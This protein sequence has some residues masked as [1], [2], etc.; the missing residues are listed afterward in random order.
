MKKLLL[1]HLVKKISACISAAAIA[2]TMIYIVPALADSVKIWNG[3]KD[4]AGVRYDG[5]DGTEENPFLISDGAQ[6]Y[7]MVSESN[8][9]TEKQY[10]TITRDIYLNDVSKTG[11]QNTANE[12][13]TTGEPDAYSFN[14]TVDGGGHTVFGLYIKS[15]FTPGL[16]PQLNAGAKI[17]NLTLSNA[18]VSTGWGYAGAFAGRTAVNHA[19]NNV[20]ILSCAVVNSRVS[21]NGWTLSSAAFVGLATGALSVENCL[22]RDT[23][24]LHSASSDD[25]GAFVGDCYF[26]G[27]VTVRNSY[28]LDI[29]PVSPFKNNS[30][31][32]SLYKCK[33]VYTNTDPI[34]DSHKAVA[35]VKKISADDIKGENAADTLKGFDFEYSWKTTSGF[36]EPVKKSGGL[37]SYDTLAPGQV[38]SGKPAKEYAGGSGTEDDPY[39]ISTAGQLAKL[40]KSSSE[41][42]TH[43]GEFFRL[44]H[45]IIL[46]DTSAENWQED[47]NQ[48]YTSSV[49]LNNGFGGHFDGNGKII[50]GMYIQ[51]EGGYIYAGLFPTVNV[52]SVIE[53]VGLVNSAVLL[54]TNQYE[55]VAGGIVGAVSA[56]EAL[57]DETTYAKVSQCFADSTVALQGYCAGAMICYGAQFSKIDNCFFTGSWKVNSP[58]CG[59][60]LGYTWSYSSFKMENCYVAPQVAGALLGC[61]NF[62]TQSY[63]NCYTLAFQSDAGVV[64]LYYTSKMNGEAAKANMVGFDYDNIWITRENETPGLRVF[65]GNEITYSN[66]HDFDII[67]DI[68]YVTISFVTYTDKEISPIVGTMFETITL[69]KMPQR[70]GYRF[71]GWYTDATLML[72]YP[73]DYIPAYDIT[74]YAKWELLGIEQGF[75]DYPA[76]EYDMGG[77]YEHYKMSVENFSADYVRSGARSLHR[78][79]KTAGESDF[80]ISYEN[81]LTVGKVYKMTFWATT[82]EESAVIEA[83]VVHA[84]W[85]DIYESN[86]GVGKPFKLKLK[87]GE[88]KQYTCN[89]TAQSKWLIIRTSGGHSVFFDDFFLFTNGENGTLYNI[90]PATDGNRDNN[91]KPDNGEPV[92]KP[93]ET[94][95]IKP[96]E[97]ANDNSNNSSTEIKK[98]TKKNTGAQ[99]KAE[100]NYTFLYIIIG[101]GAVLVVASAATL[102]VISR[103]RKKVKKNEKV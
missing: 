84:T 20:E 69:P 79:G 63:N 89:F 16:F 10:F 21:G 40:V 33:N 49:G 92:I 75:E 96:E 43:K 32:A 72:E 7:K 67:D 38:W 95:V 62:N 2:V 98:G 17:G 68:H 99:D 97:P 58:R 85:P 65:E 28:S 5:G 1:R 55:T 26:P 50:S 14:G 90:K 73:I 93:D 91:G 82:D 25:A 15:S 101:V 100:E 56:V 18:D 19:S 31:H 46:N 102:S 8:A 88:W 42:E 30:S 54:D 47:A 13:Y 87:K 64:G 70:D 103:K 45:N 61:S 35:G 44:T 22:V 76:T 34:T 94:P 60:L 27:T 36:P 83:S 52:G 66:K 71:L 23:E 6:L 3:S 78:L 48:W 4:V 11:W 41:G 12:W 24:V 74:L 77:D 37:S 51:R 59:A 39:L 57:P 81:E 53:K 86:A 29:F 80:L 9:G